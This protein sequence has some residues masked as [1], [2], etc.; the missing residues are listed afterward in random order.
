MPLVCQASGHYLY[1]RAIVAREEPE[2]SITYQRVDR[3]NPLY[4]QAVDLR[5]RVLLEPIG[6]T[7]D[8]LKAEIPGAEEKLEHFVA[9]VAHP[10]GQRVIGIVCLLPNYPEPRVGKLM[11]MA[12]DPQR[13][14]EGI[15][16]ALVVELER[17]AFGVLGLS[18]LFCHSRFDAVDFYRSLG[19]DVVGEMFME[20]GVRHYKMVFDGVSADATPPASHA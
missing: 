15:G 16:R 9:T 13:Q 2:L 10:T 6:Y 3:D 14:R 12:V 5:I 1:P 8:M 18:S 17:R 4:Q 19:W 20:A 7:M 11:Q